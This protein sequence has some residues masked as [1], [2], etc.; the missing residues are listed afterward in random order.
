[1]VATDP[2]W[3]VADFD[4]ERDLALAEA[5]DNGAAKAMEP[6]ISA[7]VERGGKLL[8]YHGT[9]DGLIPYRNTVNYYNAVVEA[10]GSERADEHVALFLVPGMDH[11]SGGSG[12]Y[13]IDW[14]A[15]MEQWVAQGSRPQDLTGQHPGTEGQAGFS[16]PLCVYPASPEYDGAGDVTQAGSYS[17]RTS[18]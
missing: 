1:V 5:Y 6:D 16:R 17:C 4:A 11:C 10:L 14:L 2:G 9:T 3:T 18:D 12:A 13:A 8:L 7:F 15:A